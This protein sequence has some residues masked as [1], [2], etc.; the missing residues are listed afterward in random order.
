MAG[1][2]KYPRILTAGDSCLIVEFGNEISMEINRKVLSL[3]TDLEKKPFNGFMETIPSYRSLAV[4][5]DPAE[6]D[7]QNLLSLLKNKCSRIDNA[8]AAPEIKRTLILPTLYGGEF[9]WDIHSVAS[10]T[11]LSLGQI[12]ELHT[13]R[14]Y[15]CYMLGFTPGFAYLGGMDERLATPRLK[16]PRQTVPAGAVGIAGSQTGFYSISSPG[17]WQIIG[18]TPVIMFD[19]FRDPP[20]FLEAGMWVRFRPI[21]EDEFENI[22]EASEKK[23]FTPE[24]LQEKLVTTS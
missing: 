17:G 9:G 4:C 6:T 22:K 15:Y 5:F 2:I 23:M 1:E 14:E 10:Y 3:K 20:F 7:I 18:R 8:S 24:I 12:I 13:Q 19:P 16:E 11:G 21:K